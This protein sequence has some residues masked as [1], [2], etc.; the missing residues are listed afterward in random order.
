MEL[1]LFVS[2]N[3]ILI[4]LHIS[5]FSLGSIAWSTKPLLFLLIFIS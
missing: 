3:M 5:P 2:Q 1:Q 4:E